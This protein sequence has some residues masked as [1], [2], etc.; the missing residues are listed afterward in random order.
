MNKYILSVSEKL[1]INESIGRDS[2]LLIKG[3]P[4]QEGRRLYVTT[5]TGSVEIKPGLKMVFI[6][7][8]IYRVIH[9]GSNNFSGKK[10]SISS[11]DG[12]KGVFNMK[13]PGKPS[14]VLNHN[15]TPFHWITL[16]H[17]D[18][19][20]AL[21]A[22]GP[23]LFD[24][25]LILE[26]LN[27]TKDMANEFLVKELVNKIVGLDS[28]IIIKNVKSEDEDEIDEFI[29]SEYDDGDTLE[30]TM[31]FNVALNSNKLTEPYLDYF[32]NISAVEYSDIDM[33][34]S[35]MGIEADPIDV[36]ISFNT[37]ASM[38]RL[39]DWEF[40]TRIVMPDST[41]QEYRDIKNEYFKSR[42]RLSSGDP[43]YNETRITHIDIY[44]RYRSI[45]ASSVP[46]VNGDEISFK[47]DSNLK[48]ALKLASKIFDGMD[49]DEVLINLKSLKDKE[50]K[51][52]I[53]SK[54]AQREY[55]I[56]QNGI[57]ESDKEKWSNVNL[58]YLN[59]L[60]ENISNLINEYK[61]L[62][63]KDNLSDIDVERS[64]D[65]IKWIED[66]L[67]NRIST[68]P[69]ISFKFM[70][71]VRDSSGKFTKLNSINENGIMNAISDLERLIKN[72]DFGFK[73][74]ELR[75]NQL[76]FKKANGN[77]DSVTL[78]WIRNINILLNP[79]DRL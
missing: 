15:K 41:N 58:N 6:G 10:V 12:L 49:L 26:S 36:T 9:N 68:N 51:M 13:N 29:E 70:N 61:E 2:V 17:T 60:K 4:T 23:R 56:M 74:L 46:N 28:P 48:K 11:E 76:A 19:G 75:Y 24:H 59:Y 25:E 21:R 50:S 32:S 5:I 38:N 71:G 39:N 30:W 35:F 64:E 78:D 65:I 14:L 43:N 47:H 3:K 40:E 44:N 8:T 53:K 22:V 79:G 27:I 55:E 77:L 20:T 62:E 63:S 31:T 34:F 18:I 52:S 7:D 1:N 73:N 67:P 16:K 57:S 66:H 33:D 72:G 37:Y 54:Y 45:H 42:E 69:A